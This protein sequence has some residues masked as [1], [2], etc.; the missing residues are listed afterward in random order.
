MKVLSEVFGQLGQET[1]MSYT[2]ENNNGMA[3][4]CINYGCIITKILVPDR[5][6]EFEN[7][8]LGYDH[9]EEYLHDSPY[10]GAVV[11]RVAGRIK[12]A[13]FKLG[14]QVYQLAKN[15]SPNHLHGGIKGFSDV[16]W[17]ASPFEKEESVGLVFTYTSPDGEEGYPGTVKMTVTYTLTNDNCFRIDYEGETDQTTLLNVTN[18][19]YFNLSGD[20]KRDILDQEL[21]LKSH[22]FY[23]LDEELLP[24][25]KLLSVEGT[26]F[27]FQNGKQIGAD[28]KEDHPQLKVG[29]GYDHPFQ[30]SENHNEEIV[31]V[32]EA[33]GRKLTVETDQPCVVVYSSSTMGDDLTIRG[34]QSKQY[35][36]ICFETQGPP[37]AIHHPNFE[38][39]VLEKGDVYRTSTTFSFSTIK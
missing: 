8:V 10:F 29:N 39:C 25:G 2:L 37:D 9:L 38:S 18:H 4:T 1:V 20:L 34:V 30:L 33:S 5:E 36:G 7:I 6:G 14:D 15:E 23:E 12:G 19:S 28:I 17:Q 22:A 26:P 13:S 24:T 31:L 21:T 27:D 32:D 11:G 35:L 3:M 16:V